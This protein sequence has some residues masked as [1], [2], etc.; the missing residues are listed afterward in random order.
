MGDNSS[1]QAN[2]QYINQLMKDINH[3]SDELYESLADQDFK[4]LDH[5]LTNF[6]ILLKQT[7]LSYQ[8]EI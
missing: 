6:I 8:D 1:R 7:Q 5:T 2:F 3:H 4:T